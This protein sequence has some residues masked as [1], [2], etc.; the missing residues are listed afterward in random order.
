LDSCRFRSCGADDELLGCRNKSIAR[1][2]DLGFV[3]IV[4][5]DGFAVVTAL[6]FQAPVGLAAVLSR[7]MAYARPRQGELTM[8]GNGAGMAEHSACESEIRHRIDELVVAIRAADL[9][10]VCRC[11]RQTSSHSTSNHRC[12]SEP[13]RSERTGPTSFRCTGVRWIMRFA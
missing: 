9:D 13:Q 7:R 2:V 4:L 8:R 5:F 3:L 10:R 12:T 1:S 6:D 11:T